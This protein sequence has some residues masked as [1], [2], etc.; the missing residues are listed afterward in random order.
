MWK[1][2]AYYREKCFTQNSKSE[3]KF[4]IDSDVCKAYV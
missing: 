3:P 2:N 4:E 1:S